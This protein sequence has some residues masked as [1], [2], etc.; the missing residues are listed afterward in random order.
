MAKLLD[1]NRRGAGSWFRSYWWVAH[2]KRI[3]AD[4]MSVTG[5]MHACGAQHGP[6]PAWIWRC[7]TDW[8]VYWSARPRPLIVIAFSCEGDVCESDREV[9][10]PLPPTLVITRYYLLLQGN[11]CCLRRFRFFFVLLRYMHVKLSRLLSVV[12]RH[13]SQSSCESVENAKNRRNALHRTAFILHGSVALLY[14]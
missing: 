3:G 10:L 11:V 14:L 7:G 2:V 6:W 12:P 9:P 8:Q 13:N 5:W 1:T 4:E